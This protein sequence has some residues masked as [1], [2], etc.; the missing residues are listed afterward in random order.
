[1]QRQA[2]R[3]TATATKHEELL[4]EHEV[5]GDHGSHAAGRHSVAVATTRWIK[6]SRRVV[7]DE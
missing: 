3:P 2:W 5:L 4:L 6:V 1:M 7:I